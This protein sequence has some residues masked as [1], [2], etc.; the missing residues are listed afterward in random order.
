MN[1]LPFTMSVAVFCAALLLPTAAVELTKQQ[2]FFETHCTD[3]HDDETQK[4]NFNLTSLQM[5]FSNPDN[6][7]KWKNV[8]DRI[9]S[10]EMPPKKKARP[11]EA[12]VKNALSTLG[13]QLTEAETK[14]L[15]ANGGRTTVRRMNRA[16]YE[17][18]LRDLLHLP[19][20][21]VKG[22]LPEDAQ[23]YG[24][25]K[26]AGDFK[27]HQKLKHGAHLLRI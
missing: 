26:V 8:Y 3:C 24:F 22:F 5:D 25:D 11:P 13:Q 6:L 1:L 7:I 23:K 27:T 14:G 19:L 10:A 15:I 4:G 9:E 20:L 12:D 17:N 16:E 21:Q 2:A 18:T